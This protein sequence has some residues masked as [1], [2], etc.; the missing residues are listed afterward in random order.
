MKHITNVSLENHLIWLSL[1]LLYL[2]DFD[3]ELFKK[4]ITF[5]F[6][7]TVD[8]IRQ[9]EQSQSD[10]SKLIALEIFSQQNKITLPLITSLSYYKL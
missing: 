4:L 5:S 3:E 8:F 7:Y 6:L 1:V 10:R 2:L 9:K